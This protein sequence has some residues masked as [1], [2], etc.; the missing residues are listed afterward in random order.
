MKTKGIH[1]K[2]KAIFFFLGLSI[3]AGFSA[4]SYAQRHRQEP[5]TPDRWT[6]RSHWQKPVQV[7]REIG[8]KEGMTIA[9]IGANEGYFTFYMA[10]K[11]GPRGKIYAT[12]INNNALE[13]IRSRCKNENVNNVTVIVGKEDDPLLPSKSVDIAL[14]V[15]VI[16]ML[17]DAPSFLKTVAKC[18]KPD[19]KLVIIQWAAEKLDKEQV[20]WENPRGHSLRYYLR[21]IYDGDFEVVQLLTFLPMQNIYVCK[22]RQ[23]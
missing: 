17:D 8:V 21:Q 9:D 3:I 14:I 2:T 23:R 16:P 6:T 5:K 18:L 7:M 19:G 12:D 1:M 13:T 11:V 10:E 22:L 4:E 15:N 20:D